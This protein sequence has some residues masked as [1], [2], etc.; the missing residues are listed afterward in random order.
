MLSH[1]KIIEKK[2]L[3]FR[4]IKIKKSLIFL[5]NGDNG[6]ALVSKKIISDKENYKYLIGYWYD[7]Y[8]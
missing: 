3:T 5:E 1:I 6:N 2:K 7:D 4:D 8:T